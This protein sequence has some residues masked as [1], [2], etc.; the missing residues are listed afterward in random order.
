MNAALRAGPDGDQGGVLQTDSRAFAASE[1]ARRYQT[2]HGDEF[3]TE[4]HK[5]L[6]GEADSLVAC[7][8]EQVSDRL[9]MRNSPRLFQWTSKVRKAQAEMK[10][11]LEYALDRCLP[12][13]AEFQAD[14]FERLLKEV[15]VD[16]VTVNN[17][18]YAYL[19][20]SSKRSP[21][22]TFGH[23][24]SREPGRPSCSTGIGWVKTTVSGTLSTK[25]CANKGV[26]NGTC[27]TSAALLRGAEISTFRR[28]VPLN[29]D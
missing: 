18:H 21:M 7:V 8:L 26:A 6:D 22:N 23:C 13:S 16:F 24:A 25:R 10:Q 9:Y 4:A 27:K 5:F 2:D 1:L 12:R 15:R 29:N 20:F 3:L 11:Y 28:I 17:T 14:R 19:C